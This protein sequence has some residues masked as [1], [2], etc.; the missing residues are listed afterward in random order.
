MSFAL[1]RKKRL[2]LNYSRFMGKLMVLLKDVREF[3]KMCIEVVMIEERLNGPK[4]PIELKKSI[5]NF[6]SLQIERNLMDGEEKHSIWVN[7]L[8]KK[9]IISEKRMLN[10]Y[11]R[12]ENEWRLQDSKKL[13]EINQVYLWNKKREEQEKNKNKYKMATNQLYGFF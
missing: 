3:N 9:R 11:M 12:R 6:V 5:H 13:T 2:F 1:E 7:D 8:Y 4:L 10:D